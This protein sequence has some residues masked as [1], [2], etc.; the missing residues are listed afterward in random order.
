MRRLLSYTFLITLLAGEL[1]ASP[2]LEYLSQS[3]RP[4][5]FA[6]WD[7]IEGA[8][9]WISGP[10]PRYRLDYGLHV[11]G[12]E[13]GE[14]LT[15]RVPAGA[16]IRAYSPHKLL[17]DEDLKVEWSNGSGLYLVTPS[18]P[19]ADGHSLSSA[20]PFWGESVARV[21]R[22]LAFGT[23]IEV[24]LFTSRRLDWL[25]HGSDREVLPLAGSAK[26]V[27]VDDGH[28]VHRYWRVEANVPAVASVVGP[29][30]IALHTR[31]ALP[32]ISHD[33]QHDYRINVYL[34]GELWQVLEFMTV[35]ETTQI[36][37]VD[38]HV[39][40]IGYGE[41]AYLVI[42]EGHYQIELR[43][44][45]ALYA[46]LARSE[47]PDDYLLDRNRPKSHQ[48]PINRTGSK[49]HGL[50][51]W[52]LSDAELTQAPIAGEPLDETALRRVMRV[53]RDNSRRDG[54]LVAAMTVR[55]WAA[56]NP[57]ER[58][59]RHF[60]K[61]LWHRHTFYRQVLPSKGLAPGSGGFAWF[62]TPRLRAPFGQRVVPTAYVQ[63]FLS[64]LAS[65]FFI[66]I[67]HGSQHALEYVLPDRNAPSALRISVDLSG[68]KAMGT[69]FVQFDSQLPRALHVAG[70]TDLPAAEFR[71]STGE[72]GVELLQ[73]QHAARGVTLSGPFAV[74]NPAAPFITA[75][76]L[77]LDLPRQIKR[78]RVWRAGGSGDSMR[79]AMAYR[80][81]KFYTMTESE[82]L[83]L[84]ESLG[85]GNIFRFFRT[86]VGHYTDQDAVQ[87]LT[88]A[89][90][91]SVKREQ[92][93]AYRDLY[94]QWLPLLRFIHSQHRRF[95]AAVQ[96]NEDIEHPGAELQ[97]ACWNLPK[98]ADA[99]AAGAA[100][101]WVHALETWTQLRYCAKAEIREQAA[102]AQ[103][104]ALWRLGEHYLAVQ[105]LRAFFLQ[106]ES[107]ELRDRALQQ[108]RDYY[109]RSEN[110]KAELALLAAAVVQKPSVERLSA[111]VDAL[112][113]VG[114]NRFAL[115]TL[116][117]MPPEQRLHEAVLRAAAEEGWWLLF[118]Q[119][120]RQIG[121]SQER[122]HWAGYRAQR[123]GKYQQAV[124]QLQ[125]AGPRGAELMRQLEIAL[126]IRTDLTSKKSA[127]RKQAI[128]RWQQLHDQM[129]GE[130][131]W[132]NEPRVVV[133]HAGTSTLYGA[134]QH[135]FASAFR[136]TNQAPLQ[137]R[138]YGPGRL[139][140]SVRPL[141][142]AG[143]SDPIDDWI[144]V[145][146]HD[147]QSVYPITNNQPAPTL[148]LVEQNGEQPG[149]AVEVTYEL[150]VGYHELEINVEKTAALI[151]VAV[152]RSALPLSV[153]PPLTPDTVIAAL[154]GKLGEQ[155]RQAAHP[156]SWRLSRFLWLGPCDGASNTAWE[157]D[158]I[159]GIPQSLTVP[160]DP[161]RDL[162][163]FAVSLSATDPVR[164]AGLNAGSE[165]SAR[166][167]G[168]NKYVRHRMHDLLWQA[169]H[170]PH[171]YAENLLM[172]EHLF[173]AHRDTPGLQAI[174]RRL[175]RS[176]RWRQI[177]SV[178]H[179]AGL[180]KVRFAGWRPEH[181][182][183][184]VRK[185]L[186]RPMR[187]GEHVVS[188]YDTLVLAV[189]N[190]RA[191][192]FEL[193]LNA[194][195]I[196]YL[197]SQVMT[198]AWQMDQ[199]PESVSI[200]T[201]K[202]KRIRI[203]Q[204]I[205]T[206][207]HLL[208][209]RIDRPVVNQYLRV[210]VHE[211][212]HD[213]MTIV[214]QVVERLYHI[215]TKE[216]PVKFYFEGPALLRID[217]WAGG[218]T[219]SRFQPIKEGWQQV[220]VPVSAGKDESL[221]RIYAQTATQPEP[222][223]PL[224]GD[225]T[226]PVQVD[227]SFWQ[228]S[229]PVD[230]SPRLP[231]DFLKLG[232]QEDG[233]WSFTTA[234]ASRRNLGEDDVDRANE[235]RFSEWALSH[236]SFVPHRASFFHTDALVRIREQGGPTWGA[237]SWIG[238]DR[239]DWPVDIKLSGTLF[240]QHADAE[241][242]TEWSGTLRATLSQKRDWNLATYHRPSIGL[243]Q[244]WISLDNTPETNQ[245]HVDQDI[246]TPYK[247]DHRRG[248]RVADSVTHRPW[249]D[250]LVH[251][252]VFAATNEN[253]NPF[254]LDNSGVTIGAK[255]LFGDWQLGLGY[256]ITHYFADGDRDDSST[257]A[258]LRFAVDGL[259][260][261]SSTDG[262]HAR[263]NLD[264][265]HHSGD[266]SVWLS[267]AW[268]RANARRLHDYR[269]GDIDFRVLRQRRAHELMANSFGK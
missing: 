57:H 23:S 79:V 160:A 251:G 53:A 202:R 139:R 39:H 92:H 6:H 189:N 129:T 193:E 163:R 167:N 110:P 198:V 127:T 148:Q 183:M 36:I 168:F 121:D 9:K 169:E 178:T 149:R 219:R 252:T 136:A 70:A 49:K 89:G 213:T 249:L 145:R 71:A 126:S 222:E 58:A 17:D 248:L 150:G 263:F 33:L 10:A 236:R 93:N 165:A 67:P 22:P 173:A 106:G 15:L 90:L 45:S 218:R 120:V 124:D 41:L 128:R 75:G 205:P 114:Q 125:K 176:V 137:L 103:V 159:L 18:I 43:T 257:R 38:A 184:R 65:G 240:A 266:N 44:N 247:H 216:N 80:A 19:F 144:I 258:R 12:L 192:H 152:S 246:F 229:G 239:P 82:Y 83:P 154:L 28:T 1:I 133:G 107:P 204:L 209:V 34:N 147:N 51:V 162:R 130:Q 264:H 134:D 111:L 16:Q 250:T 245:D 185:A 95:I 4:D 115:L 59:L 207:K 73:R 155:P 180:R 20:P 151:Q 116:M 99:R 119:V 25:A 13:P 47:S 259:G 48:T 234:L 244:R 132:R 196:A 212:H 112:R 135:R 233:T 131:V 201:H 194:E 108:L 225:T 260:W 237:R 242:G 55:S 171:K 182:A 158:Q 265:D 102:L 113:A 166:K 224:R 37:S 31:L 46:R 54:G 221:F 68:D 63:A 199:D 157:C 72:I 256:R 88:L 91:A 81:S 215:A 210:F 11:V 153:L 172:G 140:L 35:L 238:I 32:E 64:T 84:L 143:I 3:A 200:L 123:E 30:R 235:E 98:V 61:R 8:P 268:N 100:G 50:S 241:I 217:E 24:A 254:D 146:H 94:N 243:F 230:E 7:N 214:D 191:T 232:G 117:A 164:L 175:R 62:G 190:I 78:V 187:P 181:P 96:K 262:W 220:Q 21:S 66:E 142:S 26:E 60:A 74:R 42:P 174:M 76:F 40:P 85:P 255:Q 69:L 118:D 101:D 138:A 261:F 186:L 223:I 14:A 97:A 206:G 5:S 170:A 29:M 253:L 269:H 2:E 56:H 228:L 122:K 141:H 188:G 177:Q 231:D 77:E 208:R 203:S 156:W 197:P 86:A 179:S 27:N 105:H 52:E 226:Q 161:G 109:Q 227:E 211:R 87:V 267:L 195:D 104:E